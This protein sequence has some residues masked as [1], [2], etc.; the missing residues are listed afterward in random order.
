M[1][2]GCSYRWLMAAVG[3]VLFISA[4][5]V[6]GQTSLRLIAPAGTI[7]PGGEFY[8]DLWVEISSQI[9][10][11]QFEIPIDYD[12]DVVEVIEV[13]QG[14][15]AE[16]GLDSPSL[17]VNRM[18]NNFTVYD[19][20]WGRS[21]KCVYYSGNWSLAR[22][23]MRVKKNA[24][25]GVNTT[26]NII[27]IVGRT[28]YLY[29]CLEHNGI[30]VD[31]LY[32]DGIALTPFV[33]QTY[34][35]EQY[36]DVDADYKIGE[37]DVDFFSE[38]INKY[39]YNVSG[40]YLVKLGGIQM[41][42]R[43]NARPDVYDLGSADAVARPTRFVRSGT[44]G[45]CNSTAAASDVQEIPL[46][47]G[48]PYSIAILPGSNNV[49]NTAPGGD[50]TLTGMVITT[51][52]NGIS[53]TTKA[54][55]DVQAII[56]GRGEANQICVS[57]GPDGKLATT[58]GG[59]DASFQLAKEIEQI[60]TYDYIT[61]G[62]PDGIEVVYPPLNLK[63][64]NIIFLPKA[65]TTALLVRVVDE[66]GNPRPG[67]APAFEVVDGPALFKYGKDGAYRS[68]MGQPADQF[69]T[70]GNAPEGAVGGLLDVP[71]Y[72]ESHVQVMVKADPSKGIT[73]EI[74]TEV[75]IIC[76]PSN[77]PASLE[78]KLLGSPN[79]PVGQQLLADIT[80]LDYKSNP[81]FGFARRIKLITSRNLA[82]GCLGIFGEDCGYPVFADDF[83]L[84][85]KDWEV[86]N[87]TMIKAGRYYA[88]PWVGDI[89]VRSYSAV[90][91]SGYM[92]TTVNGTTF[93][94][95]KMK[96]SF[97]WSF[98][99]YATTP[100]ASKLIVQWFDN[101]S[102]DWVN[103]REIY[104][105]GQL[106]Q[107]ENNMVW[108]E[109]DLSNVKLNRQGNFSIRFMFY[110]D[111][112]EAFFLDN[113]AINGFKSIFYQ[114]FD[115]DEV[116]AFPRYMDYSNYINTGA[117]GRSYKTAPVYDDVAVIPY[118]QGEP[119]Q[120]AIWPGV[121]KK[122]DTTPAGDD[123]L[124]LINGNTVITTGPNGLCNTTVTGDDFQL[125]R[126]GYGRPFA[127]MILPGANQVLDTDTVNIRNEIINLV[128][129]KDTAPAVQVD[130]S[131]GG[132]EG[133]LKAVSIGRLSAGAYGD[134]A[135][136]K[137]VELAGYKHVYLSFYTQTLNMV[138]ENNPKPQ[139]VCEVSDD[140]GHTWVPVWDF[141]GVD[142]P[143]TFHE[144]P[145]H[146]D[147]RFN[148]VNGLIIRWRASTYDANKTQAAYVDQVRIYGSAGEPDFI[149]QWAH[150][151]GNGIYS[152]SLA[153]FTPGIFRVA[154]VYVPESLNF[155]TTPLDLPL[156]SAAT[157]VE[158][159]GLQVDPR[160]VKIM[161]A[162]FTL[163][164]CERIN[165]Q[166]IGMLAGQSKYTD[167]TNLYRLE[168]H[169][170]GRMVAPGIF[171]AECFID[172]LTAKPKFYIRAIP[173]VSTLYDPEGTGTAVQTGLISGKIFL[174]T[175]QGAA[176]ASVTVV[177]PSSGSI[178]GVANS[179]GNYIFGAVPT[180]INYTVKS[181]KTGY[182]L[183]YKAAVG[184]TAGTNTTINVILKNGADCDG[185]GTL[186]AADIDDDADGITDTMETV[187]GIKKCNLDSDNDTYGDGADLFPADGTEWLD[188]DGDG[189]GDNDEIDDDAD[190]LSDTEEADL[191]V[192]GFI[193]NGQD[194]DTDHD[195]ITDY[196]EYVR[197]T[198]PTVANPG[199]PDTDLDGVFNSQEQGG[200]TCGVSWNKIN[201]KSNSNNTDTDGDAVNDYTEVYFY[202]T[203][204]SCHDTDLD[205][206]HDNLE[207]SSAVVK[208]CP[209][210][211]IPDS[212][213]D[214][215]CDGNTTV[216]DGSTVVCADGEDLNADKVVDTGETDPCNPDSDGDMMPDGWE[217][218]YS[219]NPLVND[220]ALDPDG[221]TLNNL[222]E[223]INSANP[224]SSD[225]DGDGIR[226]DVE[227]ANGLNPAVP[228]WG[229]IRVSSDPTAAKVYLDGTQ[230]YRGRY[231]GL[232]GT[233]GVPLSVGTL[234][235]E[236]HTITIV[237]ANYFVNQ[238]IVD[239][240][241]GQT[242][243]VNQTLAYRK[244][245]VF[246]T[247]APVM[248][249]GHTVQPASGYAAPHAVD[250]DK[251]GT[252]D[253]FV[254]AY[255]GSLVY[256]SNASS[257]SLSLAAGVAVQAAGVALDAGT[258][259][260]PFVVDWNN[261]NKLDLIIG[262]SAG[263]V[264]YYA[265]NGATNFSAGVQIQA[266]GVP[267]VVGT[268]SAPVVVDWD[269]DNKKDLV[270][271]SS[272]GYLYLYLNSG[273]DAA[274]SF[275]SGASIL[276]VNGNAISAGTFATPIVYDILRHGYMAL[277]FGN[278]L[279]QIG[280]CGYDPADSGYHCSNPFLST[281]SSDVTSYIDIG[282]YAAASFAD[283]NADR[284]MDL[285]LG[286]SAG[287]VVYYQS[288]HLT[289][290]LDRSTKVDAGDWIL[291]KQSMGLC[292]GNGGYNPGADLNGDNCV[293]AADLT[294][295]VGNFGKTY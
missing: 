148:L 264:L 37:G 248:A 255:D 96:L 138:M 169:G 102:A 29:D 119:N 10:I 222:T 72:S 225:T 275:S 172:S 135:F 117:I 216:M 177:I 100:Y 235:N 140:D 200:G 57:P 115:T 173:L 159:T 21:A 291:V 191:G 274:P 32:R 212:D 84:G 146:N 189:I 74:M 7:P 160:T 150:D 251:N 26:F 132:A 286:N 98:K 268:Y 80:A 16:V 157:T 48:S 246:T 281:T 120:E 34:D 6:R 24:P 124:A 17:V 263:Q 226:D 75:V 190:G 136:E 215:L 277:G 64:G 187:K 63:E 18:S 30:K 283:V 197:G 164:A 139:F 113:F 111:A 176:T 265:G 188:S 184:V 254:G 144:I 218:M 3:F 234:K 224:N 256:Y 70:L 206:L 237:G 125:L 249:G 163:N 178:Y 158:F 20:M 170:P 2:P 94:T 28:D 151:R 128:N 295:L 46:N 145:L 89:V 288:S 107:G 14:T 285:F 79:P 67:I 69:L 22:I 180:G 240:T 214:G 229:T 266:G 51:G 244:L 87:G 165:Y 239:V 252:M 97:Q 19:S 142:H 192:D 194:P 12:R 59:D 261:D 211:N 47:Q 271:G 65:A 15:A 126:S 99:N 221:D 1:K 39:R 205:G 61:P 13:E 68:M 162:N 143:W 76:S 116:G 105:Q 27:P 114:A 58:I 25:L 101:S 33:E 257:N 43:G 232:S 66:F 83:E 106:Q 92:A 282:S 23:K 201:T 95:K 230:V 223:F 40:Q 8:V 207:G 73:K 167:L 280:G 233:V 93:T 109:L 267:L 153:S 4:A 231:M 213:G 168:V 241:L 259:A 50:D 202:N 193:T 253:L 154:A 287:L 53:E 208:P 260:R 217:K 199:E 198:D 41:D 131:A 60:L 55:D 185:D 130:S 182:S 122:L 273:T 9:S 54:G 247:S 242:F 44:N 219:L 203:N 174:P 284:Q 112:Y 258:M 262:N 31:F 110:M 129:L 279:G 245:E 204:P 250:F 103:L 137:R 278:N 195:G 183:N 276:D 118:G 11:G 220:A 127:R 171:E 272:D 269:G 49:L 181:L 155:T 227:L 90:V 289:G 36:L 56:V 243:T 209:Y 290:D 121:N 161:P 78:L 85:L 42:F 186:D 5:S 166:V 175:L 88:Q 104:G 91:G 108:E 147:S 292:K 156:V 86:S 38:L 210:A 270:I 77:P 294:V 152:S 134:Y 149:T 123:T 236:K 52:A 238:T 228:N 141:Q 81:T 179:L 133:T 196:Q 82:S 45:I 293:T 35:L 62:R 71:L